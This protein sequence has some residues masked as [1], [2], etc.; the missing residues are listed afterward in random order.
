MKVIAEGVETEQ[1]YQILKSQGCDE[2]QGYLFGRPMPEDAFASILIKQRIRIQPADPA[3][4]GVHGQ[5][6]WIPT[7]IRYG[8]RPN[9]A[10]LRLVAATLRHSAGS[11]PGDEVS[12]T[13]LA[14]TQA[15]SSPSLK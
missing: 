8:M 14:A 13:A 7:P 2:I 4:S 9:R 1:Q 6:T 3:D 11:T 5:Q 10:N 15:G 12:A